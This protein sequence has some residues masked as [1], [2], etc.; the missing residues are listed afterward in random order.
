MSLLYVDLITAWSS[1]VRQCA[2]QKC[3]P[4]LAGMGLPLFFSL[5]P[6]PSLPISFPFLSHQ[7]LFGASWGKE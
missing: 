6:F 7:C 1:T 4:G 3:T 5:L 2:L